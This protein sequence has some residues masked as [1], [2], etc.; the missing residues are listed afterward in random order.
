M[1]RVNGLLKYSRLES[2][3]VINH[4]MLECG[5]RLGSAPDPNTFRQFR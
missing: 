3:H 2:N 4:H 1:Y 5:G